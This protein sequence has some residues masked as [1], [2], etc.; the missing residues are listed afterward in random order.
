[1][2]S[3]FKGISTIPTYQPDFYPWSMRTIDKVGEWLTQDEIDLIMGGTAARIYK[4]PVPYPRMFPEARADIFG[5]N[6]K[7]D[8]YPFIPDEQILNPEPFH[9]PVEKKWFDDDFNN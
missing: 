9:I 1:M 7:E 6:W 8:W 4:L 2:G 5:D 3:Q